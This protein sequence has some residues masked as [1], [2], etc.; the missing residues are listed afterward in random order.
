MPMRRR[1]KGNADRARPPIFWPPTRTAPPVDFSTAAMSFS[2][3]DLPAPEWP[4]TTTISPS[5]TSKLRSDSASM[6]GG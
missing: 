5:A 2:S 3:V 6:P 4:L 1:R